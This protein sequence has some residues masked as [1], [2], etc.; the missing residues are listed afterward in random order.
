[1]RNQIQGV[2]HRVVEYYS[3]HSEAR[4][5]LLIAVADGNVWVAALPTSLQP[6]M[7]V[8]PLT[9]IVLD[10]SSSERLVPPVMV[11]WF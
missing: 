8:L 2:N 6:G 7:E 9:E 1:M 3:N 4:H 10:R 11:Q 5:K